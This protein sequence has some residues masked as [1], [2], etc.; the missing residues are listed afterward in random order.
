MSGKVLKSGRG[1]FESGRKGKEPGFTR[2][3][4]KTDLVFWGLDV[5]QGG[6]NRRQ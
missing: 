4:T 3:R 2:L 5:C 6:K 1:Q